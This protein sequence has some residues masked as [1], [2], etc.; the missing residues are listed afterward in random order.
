MNQEQKSSQ[1]QKLIINTSFDLF[2]K[3]G[4]A[5]TTI[6]DIMKVTC[7]SKGAF[8]HHFKN[9]QDIG[10][11]VISDIL[12]KRI[13]DGMILPLKDYE[14]Q[15][16]TALLI[17]VFT[18]RLIAFSELEKQLGCPAN[19]LI[20]EVGQTEKGC[21]ILLREIINLWRDSIIEVLNYGKSTNQIKGDTN[22]EAVATFLIASFE[23]VRG[24][25]KVYDTNEILEAYTSAIQTFISNLKK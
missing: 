24:I 1:T 12:K 23:G 19:N 10:Q 20:N 16:T 13:Y 8:Y 25:R 3:N 9:K 18:S 2:Y 22:A 11:R 17:D 5:V 15:K 21:R 6:P 7:L 4:Y 14:Q